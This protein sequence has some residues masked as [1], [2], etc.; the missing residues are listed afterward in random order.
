MN[1]LARLGL[2]FVLAATAALCADTWNGVEKVVAIGDVHGDYGQLVTLLRQAEL[3]DEK[4]NWSG[5]DAHLVQTGDVPDRGPD[6]RKIMD[7]L[8]KLEKQA[9]KAKGYVHALIGNHDAMNVYGDLRYVHPGEFESFRTPRSEELL[10]AL[11]EAT[12]KALEQ[13]PPVEGLP[14]QEA[15]RL[16]WF[17]DRPPGWVEHRRAFDPSGEYGKWITRH[18]VA[19]RVGDTLFLH[20]G[21]GPKFVEWSIEQINE[22]AGKEFDDFS[23][24]PGGMLV[25]EDGPL[26]YR[27]LAEHD[28]ALET[29]HVEALLAK[30]GV[31]RIVIG[32]TPTAGA[33]IPRFGGK[34]IQIDV[35]LSAAYGGRLACLILEDGRAYALHRGERIELPTASDELLVYLERCAELDP[36]PSPL[37]RTIAEL[38]QAP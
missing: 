27:G 22:Q 14:D 29:A 17:A 28:E 36:Q 8:Q 32:H 1:R 16:K 13:N 19:I 7:L 30:H 4:E 26:W 31:S 24:I 2:L 21:I 18:N 9:R 34:V 37:A 25:D 12:W 20:G 35:G 38:R 23:L 6:T 15:L 10:E 33:V 11:W 5:G 3:I